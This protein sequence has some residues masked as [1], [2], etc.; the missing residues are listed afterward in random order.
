M[1]EWF[2]C[3]L[4][5]LLAQHIALRRFLSL[6]AGGGRSQVEGESGRSQVGGES[7]EGKCGEGEG[8]VVRGEDV[9]EALK[10]VTPSA[11]REV[12]LEV[13]KV[14]RVSRRRH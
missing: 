12:N 2:I 1:I 10:G 13:P 8:V 4:H 11:M 5:P 3:S 9:W 14:S 7:D 6:R